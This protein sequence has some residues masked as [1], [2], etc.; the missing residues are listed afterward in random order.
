MVYAFKEEEFMKKLKLSVFLFSVIIL[1]VPFIFTVL[2]VSATADGYQA[3]IGDTYYENFTDA[4]S[5]AAEGDTVYIL[6]SF[7][8]SSLVTINK[9][10]TLTSEPP[11]NYTI[12]RGVAGNLFTI[13]GDNALTVKDII[14]NGNNLTA[15]NHSLF[16]AE[17]TASTNP[18]LNIMDGTEIY[19]FKT[20]NGGP[21]IFLNYGSLN[22]YGG[23]IHN[24]SSTSYSLSVL[25][26]LNGRAANFSGGEISNNITM[27]SAGAIHGSAISTVNISGDIVIRNN[28]KVSA[29]TETAT[30]TPHNITV[31]TNKINVSDDFTGEV[32]VY[33]DNYIRNAV[34]GTITAG[35]D[36]S[37]G[38]FTNDRNGYLFGAANISDLQWEY[39]FEN[40]VITA[41]T[42]T[43]S[44]KVRQTAI[45]APSITRDITLNPLNTDDYNVVN[46]T[47]EDTDPKVTYTLKNTAYGTISIN[48]TLPLKN[49]SG[50]I[51]T[52]K[53]DPVLS[54]E[55]EMS[56]VHSSYP[57]L[58]ITGYTLPELNNTDYIVSYTSPS[59]TES[60]KLTY[61]YREI[62]SEPISFDAV[63]IDMKSI[64]PHYTNISFYGSSDYQYA[65][66]KSSDAPDGSTV[67][68]SGSDAL[69]GF[70]AED[71]VDY[72][73]YVKPV[74]DGIAS[75]S[76]Y[77]AM[78]ISTPAIDIQLV[79][80]DAEDE[81]NS[82][83]PSPSKA[84]QDIINNVLLGIDEDN[85]DDVHSIIAAAKKEIDLQLAKESALTELEAYID[86]LKFANKY[87]VEGESIINSLYLT[88]TENINKS[89]SELAVNEALVQIK[90]ELENVCPKQRIINLWW[91]IILLSIIL[92]MEIIMV[93]VIKNKKSK[94]YKVN[95]Y[96]AF[97]APL[98]IPKH[99]ILIII[100]LSIAVLLMAVYIV[101]LFRDLKRGKKSIKQEDKHT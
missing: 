27:G 87:S 74:Y 31:G 34:F 61:T 6:K 1:I 50:Y 28:Y 71:G 86:N 56:A 36:I 92:L 101:H 53:A 96:A 97:L 33:S 45:G 100:L 69:I 85:Y 8:L 43:S 37:E 65:L 3:R 41:P 16:K 78:D 22:M 79:K 94:Q 54:S 76:S 95:S 82:Y 59:A 48:Y 80:E 30:K 40:T 81:L 35:L 89:L 42:S 64:D 58:K 15:S 55:G 44:G 29:Y 5:A 19:N 84:V 73:V 75:V 51:W 32:G 88:G 23:Y 18:T 25:S 93:K 46:N 83:V 39:E 4:C 21:V 26:S 24:N 49:D 68:T 10:V 2:P 13:T 11:N 90:L 72:S 70:D 17:G 62:T 67:W 9:S 63:L 66:L 57:G 38:K 77:K 20:I 98:I 99:A 7:T 91:L 52:V 14:F 60:G 47:F 12:T